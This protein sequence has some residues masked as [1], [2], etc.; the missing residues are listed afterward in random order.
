[1]AMAAGDLTTKAV[2]TIYRSQM[3]EYLL[4]L[5]VVQILIQGIIDT[6]E[7]ILTGHITLLPTRSHG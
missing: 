3:Q 5:M 6:L 2:M 4:N 1:M 7:L